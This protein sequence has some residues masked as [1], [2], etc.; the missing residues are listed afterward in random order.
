MNKYIP[1]VVTSLLALATANSEVLS[2][3]VA[4]HADIAASLVIVSNVLHAALPGI[5]GDSK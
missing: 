1:L 4:K 2:A 3:F 5:F